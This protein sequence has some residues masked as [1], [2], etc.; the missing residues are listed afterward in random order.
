[1]KALNLIGRPCYCLSNP[2]LENKIAKIIETYEDYGGNLT[3]ALIEYPSGFRSVVDAKFIKLAEQNK[4]LIINGV[5]FVDEEGDVN[6]EVTI[7]GQNSGAVQYIR[8]IFIRKSCYDRMIDHCKNIY[9]E[10]FE[11]NQSDITIIDNLSSIDNLI[12]TL[13][14]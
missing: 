1:M 14:R 4:T 2:E 8:N 12:F 9:C 3:E 6:Y 5:Y 13:K 10:Y 11:C 7:Y